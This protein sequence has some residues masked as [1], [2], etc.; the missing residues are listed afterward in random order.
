MPHGSQTLSCQK[1][2]TPPYLN[3]GNN[4]QPL[5]TNSHFHSHC[6]NNLLPVAWYPQNLTYTF[7]LHASHYLPLHK[8]FYNHFLV[9][10]M[11]KHPLPDVGANPVSPPGMNKEERV[12][13]GAELDI[14]NLLGMESNAI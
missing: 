5:P 3:L 4:S 6:V 11:Q 13:T 9:F 10:L 1:L 14:L 12:P 7:P 8:L 2:T